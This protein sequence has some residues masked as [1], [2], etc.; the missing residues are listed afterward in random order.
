MGFPILVRR[1]LCFETGPRSFCDGN[2]SFRVEY[3]V[4]VPPHGP[5]T[6]TLCQL[7]CATSS[8][9]VRWWLYHSAPYYIRKVTIGCPA[10]HCPQ[11]PCRHMSRASRDSSKMPGIVYLT[12]WRLPT[13][14]SLIT[15]MVNI[16]RVDIVGKTVKCCYNLVRYFLDNPCNRQLIAHPWEWTMGA[17]CEIK[18]YIADSLSQPSSWVTY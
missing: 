12:M 11:P 8:W 2:P 17:F 4:P 16:S 5:Y 1:H 15:F 3:S 10:V 7:I 6:R 13:P 14:V 9:R 18:H